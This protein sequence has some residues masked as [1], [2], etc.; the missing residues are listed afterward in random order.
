MM[1]TDAAP[2]MHILD[3]IVRSERGYA[4]HPHA[5]PGGIP[6]TDGDLDAILDMLGHH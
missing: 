4:M 6:L 2:P 5:A 1:G 3:G